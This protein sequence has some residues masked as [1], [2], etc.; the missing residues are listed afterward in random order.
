M[1]GVSL[2]VIFS[3]FHF[4][5]VGIRCLGHWVAVVVTT[6]SVAGHLMVLTRCEVKKA[7]EE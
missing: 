6:G 2:G 7:K 3:S 5:P 1:L 4:I